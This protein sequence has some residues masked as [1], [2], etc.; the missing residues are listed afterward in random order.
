MF[1][2]GDWTTVVT[3]RRTNRCRRKKEGSRHNAWISLI[4][5]W[6]IVVVLQVFR[7]GIVTT[8]DHS[9]TL[10]ATVGGVLRSAL[11]QLTPGSAYL[12]YNNS[13]EKQLL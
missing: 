13:S 6:I 10:A 11:I 7:E 5:M 9:T 4:R 3:F 12:Y 8:M 1:T 2:D